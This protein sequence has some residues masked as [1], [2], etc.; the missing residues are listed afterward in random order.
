MLA[1]SQKAQFIGRYREIVCLLIWVSMKLPKTSV[2]CEVD[3][4]LMD[5]LCK[6]SIKIHHIFKALMRQEKYD[7]LST[8]LR[9]MLN[10]PL[11]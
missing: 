11:A 5:V 10:V 6:T 8:D 3:G 1:Q 2:R 4:S 7:Q 9:K